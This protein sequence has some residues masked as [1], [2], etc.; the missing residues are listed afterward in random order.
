MSFSEKE[1]PKINVL[2]SDILQHGDDITIVC[3]L[4]KGEGPRTQLKSISW[5]KDGV[6][7]QTV[8][9]PDPDSPQHFLGP[10]V[11]RN[12][13]V[14]DGGQYTCLLDVLLRNVKEHNV[15][16]TTVIRSKLT[17]MHQM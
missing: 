17:Y 16:D 2:K 1:I 4:T 5:Y 15:S 11:F 10:L 9:N 8:R 7:L 13:S 12:V 3:K 6:L 14:R